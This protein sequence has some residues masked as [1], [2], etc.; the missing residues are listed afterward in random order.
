MSDEIAVTIITQPIT[1]EVE[2]Q[3]V[4]TTTETRSFDN[5]A[6]TT[7]KGDLIVRN[8]STN[9]RLGVGSD[10]QVL[11]GE[12]TTPEGVAYTSSPRIFRPIVI[13]PTGKTFALTDANT[14]QKSTSASALD[15]VIPTNTEVAFPIGTEIEI[16]QEGIGTVSFALNLGVTLN[17]I[18]FNRDISAQFGAVILKK[19]DTDTWAL[20]GALA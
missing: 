13:V 5:I 19:T 18:A 15:F 17:S 10:G 8:S 2:G 20:I 1:V 7:D 16:Y 14:F 4:A 3:V 12:S 9:T 11:V 6:P